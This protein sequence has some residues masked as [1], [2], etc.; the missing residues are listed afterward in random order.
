M[1][2]PL[3]KELRELGRQ[4]NRVHHAKLKPQ[5]QAGQAREKVLVACDV[6]HLPVL[7]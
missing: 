2:G 5:Q 7:L 4:L 3:S 6:H 1:T